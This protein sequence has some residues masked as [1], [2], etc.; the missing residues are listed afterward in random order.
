[1]THGAVVANLR[2]GVDRR[3]ASRQDRRRQCARNAAAPGQPGSDGVVDRGRDG[4]C[5]ADGREGGQQ[6]EHDGH[7]SGLDVVGMR[8]ACIVYLIS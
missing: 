4:P 1:V 6:L 5:E 2:P 8:V 7:M 3:D